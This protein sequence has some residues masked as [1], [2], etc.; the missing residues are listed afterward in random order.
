MS[1]LLLDKFHIG[2][3]GMWSLA[4]IVLLSLLAIF[5]AVSVYLI[6]RGRRGDGKRE[7]SKGGTI[8][9]HRKNRYKDRT[10]RRN[11]F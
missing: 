7:F 4:E 2:F 3:D 8:F 9:S 5:V 10:G 1:D 6:L 11:K